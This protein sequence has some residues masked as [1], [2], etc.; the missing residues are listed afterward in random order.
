[1]NKKRFNSLLALAFAICSCASQLCMVSAFSQENGQPKMD[2]RDSHSIGGEYGSVLNLVLQDRCGPAHVSGKIRWVVCVRI[3]P[4]FQN[5][6]EFTLSLEKYYDGT[7]RAYATRPKAKSIYLQLSGLRSKYPAASPREI[8]G[9]IAVESMN[10]DQR[11]IP[12]LRLFADQFERIRLSPVPDDA[13]WNDATKYDF[14]MESI[15]NDSIDYAIMGPGG[16][17]AHQP[18]DLLSWTESIKRLIAI[19]LD[20]VQR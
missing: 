6:M 4:G 18:N 12:Q 11:D 16:S 19:H 7:I 9:H 14:R 5:E 17:T 20:P 3:I 1:M 15:T 2:G 8:S 10:F 13:I